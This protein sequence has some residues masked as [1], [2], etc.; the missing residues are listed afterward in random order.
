MAQGAFITTVLLFALCPAN[1]DPAV[2]ASTARPDIYALWDYNRPAETEKRFRTVLSSLNAAGSNLA[3]KLELLTQ[4][5]RSEGLQDH[6]AAA[7][8]T[9]D[10]VDRQ[11]PSLSGHYMRPVILAALE[12]GRVYNSSDRPD[13]A[14]HLFLNAFRLA[15][16]AHEENLAID[17]AHMMGIIEHPAEQIAWDKKALA[18]AER[19][20]DPKARKWRGSLLNNLGWTYHDTRRY[21]QALDCFRK[22]LAFRR[23]NGGG[24][25]ARLAEFNVACALRALGRNREALEIVQ[26]Q[27][28]ELAGRHDPHGYVYEEIAENLLAL[29]RREESRP[30][31][32]SAYADLSQDGWLVRHEPKRLARIRTL[33]GLTTN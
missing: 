22:D 24:E 9:L 16:A 26:R 13:R 18:M 19:A 30:W 27:E 25:P 8:K 33:A 5:A 7:H 17:S 15:V 23:E 20:H 2:Q 12:R 31:F 32:A 11:L 3:Y 6:F 14:R 29:G 21:P 1:R 4:I 10:G 28:A